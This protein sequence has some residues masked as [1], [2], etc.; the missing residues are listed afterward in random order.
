LRIARVVK[1]GGPG[2]DMPGYELLTDPEVSSLADRV[3]EIRGK[4]EN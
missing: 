3:L 4:N 2:T 1:F